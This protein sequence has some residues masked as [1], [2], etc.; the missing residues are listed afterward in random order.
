MSQTPGGS[1]DINLFPQRR[2]LNRGWSREGKLFRKMERCV[3]SHP[4]VFYFH[5]PI[6]VDATWIPGPPELGLL[7]VEGTWWVER[8]ANR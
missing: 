6:Y 4:G 5:R 3:A 7:T 2:D 8:F 1:L